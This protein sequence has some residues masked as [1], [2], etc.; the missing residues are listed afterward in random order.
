MSAGWWVRPRARSPAAEKRLGADRQ[1]RDPERG[2]GLKARAVEGGRIHLD[3]RFGGTQVERVAQGG[4]ERA[5]SRAGLEQA[6]RAAAE[7][8]RRDARPAQPRSLAPDLGI[9]R[10]EVARRGASCEPGRSRNRNTDNERRRTGCERRGRSRANG[11]RRGWRA[12]G[13]RARGV[14]VPK[15][16]GFARREG[17]GA[18]AA[19]VTRALIDVSPPTDPGVLRRPTAPRS[20]RGRR[21]TLATR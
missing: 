14:P 16:R 15:G 7:K 18:P 5:R 11:W 6:R 13:P 17:F 8:Q 3:R 9:E 1:A 21:A 2:P 10:I 20:S 4:A 12:E 19:F